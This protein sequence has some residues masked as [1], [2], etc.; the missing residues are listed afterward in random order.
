VGW[1]EGFQLH[2]FTRVARERFEEFYGRYDDLYEILIRLKQGG[3]VQEVP[4]PEACKAPLVREEDQTA[5]PPREFSEHMRMQWLLLKI[6]RQAGEKVWAPR[7]DQQRI[8]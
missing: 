5:T 7:N 1:Q 8:A 3:Q 2:G 6:G 4:E